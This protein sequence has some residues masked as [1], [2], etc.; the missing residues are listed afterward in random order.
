MTTQVIVLTGGS[1]SGK[2]GIARCLQA[3]LPAP[4]LSLGV[5]TLIQ[6]M[7]VPLQTTAGGIEF[8]ADGAMRAG[9]CRPRA[10]S[11]RG[12]R[13]RRGHSG[14]SAGS[15]PGSPAPSG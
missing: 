15:G 5:G 12:S 3:V 7:P 4:W 13:S 10:G 14:E 11:S 1:S 8:A 9:P 6:A 2:S